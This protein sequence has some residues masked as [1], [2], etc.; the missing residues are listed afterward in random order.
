MNLSAP[1][2]KLANGDGIREGPTVSTQQS[3]LLKS[4][5]SHPSEANSSSVLIPLLSPDGLGED[6]GL[7][8]AIVS[9]RYCLRQVFE[10][11]GTVSSGNFWHCRID[12][13]LMSGFPR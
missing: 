3:L 6:P 10:V 13:T 2:A 1:S 4:L 12:S 7:M 9:T 8:L 11:S 5:V